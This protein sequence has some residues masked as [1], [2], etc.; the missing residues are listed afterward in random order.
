MASAFLAKLRSFRIAAA[1]LTLRLLSGRSEASRLGAFSLEGDDGLGHADRVAR[2]FRAHG[3]SIIRLRR[4][5]ELRRAD[6]QAS[7]ARV[8]GALVHAHLADVGDREGPVA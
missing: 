3:H 4:A 6:L 2:T 8:G 7:P 1:P 5:G